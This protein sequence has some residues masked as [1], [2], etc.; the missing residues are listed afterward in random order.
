MTSETF[1]DRRKFVH[2]A[3]LST[4]AT[5]ITAKSYS[6]IIGA[7]DRVTPFWKIAT[8]LG[9]VIVMGQVK[10]TDIKELRFDIFALTHFVADPIGDLFALAIFPRR[11]EQ[12][13]NEEFWFAHGP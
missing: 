6:Q 12:S 3:A 11:S 1:Y 5:A 4:A 8:D 7:N 10:I 13:R 2:A 9:T